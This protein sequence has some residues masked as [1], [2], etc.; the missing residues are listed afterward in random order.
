MF[1]ELETLEAEV[2]DA[3]MKANV[4]VA[5]PWTSGSWRFQGFSQDRISRADGHLNEIKLFE[6]APF[7]TNSLMH[8][9]H[10]NCQVPCVCAPLAVYIQTDPP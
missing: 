1:V 3:M 6:E 9:S 4:N 8:P 2:D 10:L 7:N 5:K